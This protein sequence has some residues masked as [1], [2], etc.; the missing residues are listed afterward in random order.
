M[1]GKEVFM[2]IGQPYSS[3][4]GLYYFG[5]RFYD[6]ATG[7]FIT[8]DSNTGTQDDPMSLLAVLSIHVCFSTQL[9]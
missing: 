8:E 4:T 5:A 6:E 3:V 2:Y 9:P 1:T 7:R